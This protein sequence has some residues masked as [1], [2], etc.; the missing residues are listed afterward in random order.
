MN[1]LDVLLVLLMVYAAVRGFRQGALSQ[2]AAFGG[3]VVGIVLGA[4]FA[5]RVASA[6]VEGPG[7]TLALATLGVLLGSFLIGQGIGFAIGLRLRAAA[8]GVGAAPADRAAGIAVGLLVLVVG[9]WLLGSAF[10]HGPLQS[11]AQQI[12]GSTVMA[13]IGRSLPPAPDVFGRVAAYLDQQGF[14]QVFSGIAGGPTA[15]PVD[16]PS[17]GAVAAAAQA[18]Q[19]STVQ[20]Q[21]PGCGGLS[22]G[23]GFVIQP[24]FVVTNAHVIAGAESVTVRD[25]AGTHDAV[26]VAFDSA[27]DLAVL[28]SPGTTAPAIGWSPQPAER[29]VQGATL[30]YPGGQRELAIK[31]A[32][33]RGR[34]TAIGRDI[35]GRGTVTREVLT[36]S[37]DVVRGDSG[38]PFVTSDGA[39]GGVVFAAAAGQPGTGY[40][41]TSERVRP[42]VEAA[43]A[44]N[45]GVPTGPCRF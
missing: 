35:Y 34:Q 3:A 21:A 44:Q 37:A 24:G 26:T 30:G 5:P 15:P 42:D 6:L 23:S 18:G 2:L 20:I 16:P 32:T 17:E 27:L 13:T 8:A 1:L 33:V 39:V 38:G 9:I 31:P 40:A 4:N 7:P 19:A 43:I 12:R 36:L 29:A 41:L 14:P 10:A 45:T 25:Q 28:S 22:T 11:V